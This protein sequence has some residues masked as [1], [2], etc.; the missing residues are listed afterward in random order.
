MF[1]GIT[2]AAGLSSPAEPMSTLVRV[3]VLVKV[4]RIVESYLVDFF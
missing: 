2:Y 1:A 3:S 4:V